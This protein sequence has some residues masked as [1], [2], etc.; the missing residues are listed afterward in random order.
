VEDNAEGKPM[1]STPWTLDRTVNLPF[2]L[3]VIA[4]VGGGVIWGTQ[5]NSRV[6]NVEASTSRIEAAVSKLSD[7]E[8]RIDRMDERTVA[9]QRD[10]ERLQT[11][12][13]KR[14]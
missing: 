11:Y 7:N 4:A 1:K 8:A 9:L 14:N 10:L 6:G 12:S 3:S 2:L 5:I 13:Y